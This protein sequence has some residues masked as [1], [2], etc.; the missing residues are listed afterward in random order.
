MESNL[1]NTFQQ[2]KHDVLVTGT[3][4]D[5]ARQ[6]FVKSFKQHIQNSLLPIVQATYFSRAEPAYLKREGRAPEN[7]K[8]AREAFKNDP[9]FKSYL[10]FQRVSQELKWFSVLEPLERDIG[11]LTENAKKLPPA[12]GSV[13]I[14]SDFK[15]PRYISEIDIHCMPGGYCGPKDATE[16]HAGAL[17]DRGV[18]LYSMGY[19]G[20]NNDDMSENNINN[21]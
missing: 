1:L 6:E 17:Y 12:G 11:Q 20:P 16:L 14:P 4:D 8:Q 21:K 5:L 3:A 10:C 2:D 9:I 7:Y 18:Y 13:T 19:M 15:V